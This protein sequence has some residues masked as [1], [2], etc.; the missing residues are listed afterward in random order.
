MRMRIKLINPK[1]LDY[2]G[3]LSPRQASFELQRLAVNGLMMERGEL[4]VGVSSY[5]ADTDS[6]ENNLIKELSDDKVAVNEPTI[7][8]GSALMELSDD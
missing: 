7:E 6:N 5:K 8:L 3:S 4:G 1:L 2:L